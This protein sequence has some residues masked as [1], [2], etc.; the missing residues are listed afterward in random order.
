[1]KFTYT[2]PHPRHSQVNWQLLIRQFSWLQFIVTLRLPKILSQWPR[3]F[4][5][6]YAKSLAVTVAW[7]LWL[8]PNSLLSR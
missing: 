2:N 1:M 6:L 4:H 8:I 7:P 5:I 3:I